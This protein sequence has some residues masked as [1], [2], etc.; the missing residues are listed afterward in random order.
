LKSS[1]NSL[2]V[3]V[4]GTNG[5]KPV[6]SDFDN[7]DKTDVAVYRP[8][9]GYWYILKSSDG[10]F[11]AVNFG[12]STDKPAPADYDGDG[13]TDIAI[14]RPGVGYYFLSTWNNV[15]TGEADYRYIGTPSAGDL[16]APVRRADYFVAYIWRP[17]SRFFG[18]LSSTPSSTIGTSGDIPVVT[19]YVVE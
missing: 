3:S 13:K 10:S 11:S 1:D 14:Y 15:A 12:I 18:S 2:S 9:N 16:P 4:F 6:Q 17:A 5:D 19:P 8:A 7:D